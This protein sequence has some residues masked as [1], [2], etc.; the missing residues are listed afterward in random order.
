MI[1]T[2]KLPYVDPHKRRGRLYLAVCRLSATQAGAWIAE[3][4]SWKLDPPLLKLTGG[5]LS[6]AGP[7]AIALLESRGART[8]LP[9]R[10]ATLYFNDGERVTIVASKR[11]LPTNPAWYYNLRKDPEILFGGQPFHAE[12]VQD[13]GERQRLSE[14][15]DRVFPQYAE[16]RELAAKAGREIPI[17]QLLPGQRGG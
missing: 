3:N 14:L 10:N 7:L 5:R 13:E 1:L 6:T 17:F 12:L 15:A 8:G 11:G 16:Y 9:R 4:I 2:P